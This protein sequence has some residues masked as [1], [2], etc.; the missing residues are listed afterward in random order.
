MIRLVFE[1]TNF[2][3]AAHV[4]GVKA[5]THLKSFDIDCPEIENFLKTDSL[6]W[7]IRQLVGIEVLLKKEK[8]NANSNPI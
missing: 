3:T 1:E 4:D 8:F 7:T 2:G 6:S 5:E